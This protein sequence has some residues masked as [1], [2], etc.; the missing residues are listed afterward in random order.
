MKT[1]K[2]CIQTIVTGA[3]ILSLITEAETIAINILIKS[4][5]IAVL[6]AVSIHYYRQDKKLQR[7]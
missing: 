3:V 2:I 5:A 7:R 1:V 4:V 6:L